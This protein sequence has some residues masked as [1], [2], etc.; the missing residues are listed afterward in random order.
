MLPK[1]LQ[2]D[3]DYSIIKVV[4]PKE[5]LGNI[6]RTKI[7]N[8]NGVIY[9][10]RAG[11]EGEDYSPLFDYYAPVIHSKY[12]DYAELKDL[13]PNVSFPEDLK[14]FD[15]MLKNFTEFFRTD[16]EDLEITKPIVTLEYRGFDLVAGGE[17]WYS[18]SGRVTIEKWN[19][20]KKYFRYY[21]E[22]SD[23]LDLSVYSKNVWITK[24]KLEVEKILSY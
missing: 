11:G 4:E 3:K 12:K 18:L 23:D 21:K 14:S 8:V 10:L 2:K 6:G 1:E 5:L 24:N 7:Y 17:G 22:S 19:E 9:T 13:K 20:I 15:N 16:I